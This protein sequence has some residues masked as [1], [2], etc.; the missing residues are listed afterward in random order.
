MKTKTIQNFTSLSSSLF[1]F[2][3]F[4]APWFVTGFS[5]GESCFTIKLNQN[6]SKTGWQ[7]QPSFQLGLH[8]KDIILLELIK[9]FWGDIGNI[10]KDGKDIKYRVT[11]LKDLKVIIDHFDKFP[12]ITQ[13]KADY[14]FFKQVFDLVSRKEH[15]TEE[16][17]HKIMQIRASMNK[18]L[19]DKLKATFPGINLIPRPR[20]EDQ[21]IKDPYW[22]AGF[23]AAEGCFFVDIFNSK[24]S[25]LGLTVKLKVQISQDCRDSE[26]LESLVTLFGCGRVERTPRRSV[27]N[28]VVTN[29]SDITDKIIPFF[30]KYPIQGVK[31][32]DYADFCKVAKVMKDKGHLTV[33][34]M[35]LIQKIKSGMNT[36]R[37]SKNLVK[38]ESIPYK[39]S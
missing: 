22:L 5:D 25:K 7:I 8:E 27:V 38:N 30:N 39:H 17:F 28:F 19:S 14:V 15:L 35:E 26:L 10:A 37:S 3:P 12:L 32:L 23:T 20:V 9:K 31:A 11:S 21:E 24:T 36:G 16:G 2:A 1:K 33:D 18:G 13:K 34:G 29:L 4:L 6:K